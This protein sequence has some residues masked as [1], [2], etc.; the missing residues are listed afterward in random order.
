MII[1][2]PLHSDDESATTIINRIRETVE[3]AHGEMLSVQHGAPWGRRKFAYPIRAYAGGESSRRV[4]NEGFYVLMNIALPTSQVAGIERAIK[5]IDPIL[6]YLLILVEGQPQL[7]HVE[8]D[9][10]GESVSAE[11]DDLDE[12]D[13]LDD[14]DLDEEDELDDDDL[15]E[16][17]ELDDDKTADPAR[18]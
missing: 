4:F 9:G 1:I 17:D 10:H 14:D 8:T 5:L 11:D 18:Q 7:S 16:E 3:A 15:D 6:R 13:E 2:S 12:E